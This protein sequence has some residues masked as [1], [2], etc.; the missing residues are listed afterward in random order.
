MEKS[1]FGTTVFEQVPRELNGS[2]P[3]RRPWALVIIIV[4]IVLFGAFW[5]YER[6]AEM[7]DPV[8]SSDS[9]TTPLA[10]TSPAPTTAPTPEPSL[11]DLQTATVNT[12]VPDFSKAF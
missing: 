2:K 6:R 10:S 4:V 11:G 9:S 12:A 3:R 8:P 5:L 7:N 1:R